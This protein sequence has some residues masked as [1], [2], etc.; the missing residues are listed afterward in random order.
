[1]DRALCQPSRAADIAALEGALRHG[2]DA[3]AAMLLGNWH[4]DKRRHAEAVALWTRAEAALLDAD[5]AAGDPRERDSLVIVLRNLGIA[6]HNVQGDGA[7]AL[8]Y[9]GRARAL[10]PD[11]AKL[12]FEYDQLA[13]RL[14]ATEESRL[15]RLEAHGTLVGSRDDLSVVHAGLLT[16]SGRAADARRW[17]LA[18]VFQPWEGGEGQALAAWDAA[19][20]ALAE[21]A[22]ASGD[23]AGA[24]GWLDSAIASPASLGEARHP[25]ANPAR[26]QLLR[27]DALAALGRA[28]E[29]AIAWEHA[30]SFRGDFQAMGV[31]D[32]SEQSCYSA[33]AL[34]NLGRTEEAGRLAD[35]LA[36][37]IEELA[38]TPAAI[39]FFATSL[40]TML[41]FT[42]DPQEVRN[43]TVARLRAQLGALRALRGLPA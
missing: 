34:G 40:P 19:N 39:D 43:R 35:G 21:E 38:A 26:L 7:R 27:G 36:G 10:A 15:Q 1:M 6:A 8:G 18:R 2:E 30:A 16:G 33:L 31:Q 11:D 5:A 28:D 4:Y 12:L 41:L 22:L 20:I 17:L 13:A 14:G 25:L 37:H 42:E 23:A 24:L 32:Y 9:F 29:A 3:L